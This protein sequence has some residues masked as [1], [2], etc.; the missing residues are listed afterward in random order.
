MQPHDAGHEGSLWRLS[1][2]YVDIIHALA[3]VLSIPDSMM[4]NEFC[5]ARGWK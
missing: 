1:G 2:S 4:P 5:E 3:V